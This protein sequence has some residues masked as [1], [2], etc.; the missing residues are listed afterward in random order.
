MCAWINVK[1]CDRR[2]FMGN[3]NGLLSALRS[4]IV[5]SDSV[6]ATERGVGGVGA[7][8]GRHRVAPLWGSRRR[9]PPVAQ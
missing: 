5:T 1:A 7:P 8:K 9:T 3:N 2:V 4:A 6:P